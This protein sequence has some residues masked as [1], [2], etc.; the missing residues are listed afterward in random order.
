MFKP[1]FSARMSQFEYRSYIIDQLMANYATPN[2]ITLQNDIISALAYTD[3]I[4]IKFGYF[5][6]KF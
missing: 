1:C 2:D 5:N 4:S 6:L 3:Y